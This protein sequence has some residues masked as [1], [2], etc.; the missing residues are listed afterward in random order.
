MRK[1]TKKYFNV[2][3][4]YIINKDLPKILSLF[5]FIHRDGSHMDHRSLFLG[6]PRFSCVAHF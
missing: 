3:L 2:N 1:S 6:T 5:A 4:T